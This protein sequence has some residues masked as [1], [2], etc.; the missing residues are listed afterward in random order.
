MN[1]GNRELLLWIIRDSFLLA[2]LGKGRRQH[3]LASS[4]ARMFVL[5]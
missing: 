4:D 1:I 5:N 2:L 3:L